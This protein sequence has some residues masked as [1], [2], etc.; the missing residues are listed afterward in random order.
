MKL[1]LT[2]RRWLPPALV[3]LAVAVRIFGLNFDQSNHFHPDERRIA[4]AVTQLSL[5]P[6]Q[7]NPH[8]FAYGSFPLY[9]TK[10]AT[11]TLSLVHPWFS[12][13]DAAILVGRALSALWGAATVILLFVL[14]RRLFGE[15]VG[16]LAGVLLALTVLH[17]QNSHFATNDVLLTFLVLLA[18]A[19]MLRITEGGGA[20][21]FAGAG[22]A[23][24]LA[25]ATKFSAL[26]LLLPL[27][28][29]ALL[30]WR[31]DRNLGRALRGVALAL[32]CALLGFAAGEPYALLDARIYLRDVLEQSRMVR[33]AGLYPYTNQYVGVPKVLYDL[34]ELV[35]WGMGPLLGFAALVGTALRLRPK[36]KRVAA[37]D[38]ILLAWVV[39]YFALTASFDV[40]F[41]RYLLPIYP[42]LILWGAA[43][44]QGWAERSRAGRLARGTVVAGTALYLLAFLAI[45]TRPHSSVS[46]SAWFYSHVPQGSKVLI[47]DWDEGFPLSLPGRSAESYHVSSFPFYDP[48]DTG[49]IARLARE[50][51]TS[52]YVV[53]Q[54]KR[55]YGAVTRV[56]SKYPLTNN[57]F[58]ELFAADLGYT[59]I[60]DV[61]SRPGLLG[62][63]LPTELAD[64]SFSVYDHPKVLI[65]QNVKRLP[66]EAIENLIRRGLPSR[67]LSR[68]DMLLAH[69]GAPA[70]GEATGT[71]R[72]SL[73]ATLLC[74]LLIEALGLAAFA[75]LRSL[76]PPRAGLYALAKVVGVL[77]F[78]YPPWLAASTLGIPF[79]Q[80]MLVGWALA[81]AVLGW[82][83]SRRSREALP[84]R[85]ELLATEAAV[86]GTF[87]FFL[88]LRLLNPEIFWGEKPMDF[89]FLNAL[90]RSTSMPPPEP[91]FAGS[92]LIYTYFG[93][94]VVAAIG[95]SLAIEPAL[96]F[97]LGIALMAGLTAASL[98]AAGTVLGANWRVG[99]TAV[100]LTLF[101]GNFSG[102]REL[103]ARKAVDFDYFWA[104]SRVVPN[105]INEYPFWSFTFADLHA[106]LLVMPWAVAFVCLILL[107]VGRRA[108]PTAE[109]P[110]IA[111]LALLAVSAPVLG[112][113]TVTNGWS[114][115]TYVALLL[116]A[117]GADWLTHHAPGGFVRLVRRGFA[118]V[119]IPGLVVVGG[120]FLLY[121]PFWRIFALPAR[122]WGREVGPYA[123]PT[124]FLTIFGVFLVLLVPFFFVVWRRLMAPEGQ[125]LTG[126]QR[127]RVG[128]VA[129][130]LVLSVLDLRALASLSLRQAESVRTLTLALAL[131][132]LYLTFH[133]RTPERF[134]LPLTLSTFA[135]ALTAGCEFVFVWDRMNTL[136]KFYLEAWFLMGL[137]AAVVLWHLLRPASKPSVWTR[138]WRAASLAAVAVGYFTAISGAFGAVTHRHTEGPRLTLD[139]TAYL[140]RKAPG[141]KAA[142]DWLNRNI[143]GIPVLA[144][145]YGP[146]YGDFTRVSMNT[147]L[148]VV[149]GWDYH[150]Y[151]RGH[152]WNEINRRKA[153]LETIY[154]SNDRAA[155]AAALA[156]YH[157]ALVYVGPLERRTYG[158][159][160][161]TSFRKWTD[162]LTPLYENPTA[163][164]FAVN[165]AFQGV[166]PVTTVE[167]V[168]ETPEKAG[169][170][171]GGREAAPAQDRPGILRQPRGL[172]CDNLGNV[173]VADFGNCRIQK[174][175]NQLKHLAAWGRRGEE[176][177]EFQDPCGVA[178]GPDGNVY[179]ADTWN[180]RVQVF[181][182]EG[183]PLRQWQAD[184]FGPRGIAT[185]REGRAYVADTGN[186]RI[187]RFSPTGAKEL[188]WG[189]KGS[190]PG[191]LYEPGGLAVDAGGRVFVCDN[192]NGRM[193]VFDRDGVFRNAFAVPGWRREVFSEPYVALAADG[194]IWVTVPLASEVRAYS[195]A[196]ALLRTVGARDIPGVELKRPSGLA[197]RP[198][199]GRLL[200]SD[201]EGQ[202]AVL[203]VGS[204]SPQATGRQAAPGPPPPRAARTTIPP[205][206]HDT[207]LPVVLHDDASRFAP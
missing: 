123:H 115:P 89:S 67:P 83:F 97:N 126:V 178:I 56:P 79:T 106:H 80:S 21:V 16:L 160:N 101:A 63:E 104:T 54:T 200:V 71:V 141:E 148:P 145:A 117:L 26:P 75:A 170:E 2:R 14:G 105:T 65:F 44:L 125:P 129:V 191:E 23:V 110:R 188:E 182:P 74:V 24:G 55:L 70:G 136:F 94:F 194:T 4:E 132:G 140:A 199:D 149:L 176:I 42:M 28:V 155:V 19:L 185:D 77:A 118:A 174:F 15:A 193:V 95:K 122:Q 166:V 86:W 156:R 172:A 198:T 109:R 154:T 107:W 29:A 27:A 7:L 190:A 37:A 53:L 120:A 58:R 127:L 206:K 181:D 144:E 91:W 113:I 119:V 135:L 48:D 159:G 112:A 62:V 10:L 92:P 39:P 111:S 93:H 82:L 197:F 165:G 18:L 108:E 205:A 168:A 68:T 50:L 187:V 60:R 158:G 47:Q 102:V 180:G 151:Q 133:R 130:G 116:F 3:V 99:L 152:G 41:P 31:V 30:R 134:R 12:S 25:V 78:A 195:G 147:G 183:K 52:D 40:K 8:F 85:S 69:A 162:L 84:P 164:V 66:A 173:Y 76:F 98:L 6:A 59:L 163:T 17:V 189:A 143:A 157:T 131:F 38:W 121:R 202:V 161:L 20:W 142:F 13:Y 184:F 203:N 45:Y 11:A 64:E 207:R 1:V 138:L 114:M 61:A 103:L 124:D 43:W 9:V 175:D 179:I 22:A 204:P 33:H 171:P 146:S 90:Y 49:K 201:I 81:L 35:V 36:G 87:A 196:G 32:G 153:E 139:G 88:A 167:R 72:S 5:R 128:A 73:V 137:S 96:M 192:S 46:A 177:G 57:F 169:P 51:A 150:V 186:S 100:L 34:R